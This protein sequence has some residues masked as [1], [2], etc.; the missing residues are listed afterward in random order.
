MY[1][2]LHIHRW[3][4]PT[5]SGMGKPLCYPG[6]MKKISKNVC[7]PYFFFLNCALVV[8]HFDLRWWHLF[9]KTTKQLKVHL[10]QGR[11]FVVLFQKFRFKTEVHF[12]YWILMNLML[13]QKTEHQKCC[14]FVYDV[15]KYCGVVFFWLQI[16]FT[17]WF[18]TNGPGTSLYQFGPVIYHLH[19]HL[20]LIRGR[21]SIQYEI[22]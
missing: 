20:H 22:R 8:L 2:C 15:I 10:Y 13:S 17:L 1:P 3:W 7:T 16:M 9:L 12:Q 21:F 6:H 5:C 19:T 18:L 11:R 4:E 14:I